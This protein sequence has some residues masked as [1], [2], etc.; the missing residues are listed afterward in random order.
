VAAGDLTSLCVLAGSFLRPSA[1]GWRTSWAV[2]ACALPVRGGR[3]AGLFGRATAH[4]SA[5]RGPV[6]LDDGG[7]GDRQRVR[8]STRAPTLWTPRRRRRSILGAAR[9][10]GRLS[11]RPCWVG[12]SKAWAVTASASASSAGVALVALGCLYLLNGNG[13]ERGSGVTAARQTLRRPPPLHP[14]GQPSSANRRPHDAR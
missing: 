10:R 14:A 7:P 4:R 1:D 11:C 2:S 3:G 13:W 6:L 8:L 5:C 12:R 9:R